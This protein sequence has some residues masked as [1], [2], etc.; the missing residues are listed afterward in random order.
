MNYVSAIRRK[1]AATSGNTEFEK[2]T[3]IKKL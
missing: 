1:I 2:V 3:K